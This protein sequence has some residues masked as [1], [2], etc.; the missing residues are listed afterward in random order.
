MLL[1]AEAPVTRAAGGSFALALASSAL[2]CREIAVSA[3]REWMAAR[4]AR[5]AVRVGLVGKGKTA[6]QMLALIALLLAPPPGGS[7]AAFS[8]RH[9]GLALLYASVVLSVVSA[10]GYFTAA[11]PTLCGG[12]TQAR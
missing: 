12:G 11:W 5:A 7:A 6:T 1:T 4:G 8:L 3:L 2:V 10:W 9:V